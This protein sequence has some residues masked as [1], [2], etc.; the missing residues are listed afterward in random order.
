[1]LLFV[2]PFFKGITINTKMRR[3]QQLLCVPETTS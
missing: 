3:D 1:M 2:A